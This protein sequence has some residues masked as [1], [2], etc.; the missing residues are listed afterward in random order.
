MKSVLAFVALCWA[1]ALAQA[2]APA[3]PA[4]QTVEE[5]RDAAARV[6]AE[7][8]VPGAGLALVRRD[9]IEWAGG[10]GYADRERQTPVTADTNF[11][12]GSISKT[13]VAMA[14]VQLAE[15][16]LLDLDAPVYEV[17]PE[18]AIDNPWEETHPVRVIHLLQHTA[19]FDDMHFN[20][21]DVRGDQ[22]ERSLEDVL[23][24]NPRSRRVRW[25]PGTR[26]AYSNPGYGVAG[27]ILETTAAMPYEDYIQQEIFEPLHMTASSFRLT[28]ADEARLAQG[29]A[30]PDGPPVGFTRIYLRPAGNMHSSAADMARFVQMLLGWGE[31]GDAFVIDPEYLGNM[32]QPRTTLA[33]EAGLRNGYGS[34]I[35]TR[36]DLPYKMLGHDGCI[37][38]FLSSYAYSPSRDAGY[39]VLLNSTGPRADEAMRRLSAM[40]V[41]YLKRDVA[42]P[43]KPEVALD[44]AT[45]DRYV[46]Y[47]QD[48]NPRNQF[49]WPAQSL[50]AGQAIVREGNQLFVQPPIGE[51]VRL[52]PVSES[53][54][55]LDGELDASRVFTLDANGQMVMAAAQVYAE[56]V[57]RWRIEV[58]RV[59]VL[60][61]IP[62]LASVFAVA[63]VWIARLRRAEPRGFWELKVALLLCPLAVLAPAGALAVTPMM[64]WGV[65]NTATVAVFVGTLAIPVL[66][67]V[68]A[69]L[70][71]AAVREGASRWL[72]TYAALVGLAMGGMSLYLSSHEM[73]GLRL[74]NY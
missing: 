3:D 56:R 29:H 20:E 68:V 46:G 26:M 17:A 39:V 32:E 67:L 71:L 43:D 66:A 47:Y 55:R 63:I 34:G 52:I 28:A 33:A 53:A 38:G 21:M 41:S 45:L 27:L 65:R 40:A 12:V 49:A 15:D 14:L 4:P 25:P 48:A 73:L 5:F 35:F 62:L 36:L 59:P 22:P 8:G 6:L 30:G 7:T 16:G 51:R 64:N 50:F 60:A 58:M 2:Q 11:R 13:F 37:D 69:L 24:L 31:L 42:P 74:W 9:E 61:T 72:A 23:R 54:F 10:V 1:A 70:T 18:V 57:P 44:A 19:G